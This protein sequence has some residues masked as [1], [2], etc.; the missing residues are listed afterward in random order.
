MPVLRCV[1]L[2]AYAPVPHPYVYT[3]VGKPNLPYT[4]GPSREGELWYGKSVYKPF[5]ICTMTD[6]QIAIG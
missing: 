3:R 6:R 2:N 4:T 5:Y 1:Q